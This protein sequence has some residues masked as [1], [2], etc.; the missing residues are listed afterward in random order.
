MW[1]KGW[2]NGNQFLFRIP[3]SKELN[4]M[5]RRLQSTLGV[6]ERLCYSQDWTEM[7][8]CFRFYI[9]T[10]LL[11]MKNWNPEETSS[12]S[13]CL[14]T[15]AANSWQ[16]LSLHCIWYL[17]SHTYMYFQRANICKFSY[18]KKKVTKWKKFVFCIPK[19][20]S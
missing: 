8:T 3:L 6:Y 11:L 13:N 4:H 18:V 16:I 19:V 14:F 20:K 2:R 7:R 5:N 10:I 17:P 12:K 15:R 9:R 1:R